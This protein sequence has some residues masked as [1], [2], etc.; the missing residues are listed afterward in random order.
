MRCFYHDE[1]DAVGTCKNC[2]RGVCLTCAHDVENGLAC[3]DRCEAE[4]RALN[5]VIER[6]KTSYEKTSAAYMRTAFF[7][8]VIGLVILA[9]GVTNWR[10][11]GPV[12][13]AASLIFF[14]N[15]YVNFS[16]SRRFQKD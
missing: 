7:Y 10:G 13:V 2:G 11:L 1:R 6:N 9:G 4:V 16:T 3:R 5:R 15:A 8:V 14:F 12:L